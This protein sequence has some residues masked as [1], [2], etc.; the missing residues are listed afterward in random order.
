LECCR[1]GEAEACNCGEDLARVRDV[2]G[3]VVLVMMLAL[4][5]RCNR[6]A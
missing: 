3:M 1:G 2:H 5:L 4:A 6:G